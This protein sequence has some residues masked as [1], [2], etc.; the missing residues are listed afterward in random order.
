MRTTCFPERM[1]VCPVWVVVVR[2][3]DVSAVAYDRDARRLIPLRK[4]ITVAQG[5]GLRRKLLVASFAMIQAL[6]VSCQSP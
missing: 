6:A 5:A 4:G 3:K 1:N 2:P